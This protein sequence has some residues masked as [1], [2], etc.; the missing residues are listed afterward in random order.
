MSN[1]SKFFEGLAIGGILGF[2]CGLLS[3][4]KPGNEL[5]KELLT[6][7]EDFYKQASES[8]ADMKAKTNQAIAALQAKG[9]DLVKTASENFLAKKESAG[10]HS[11]PHLN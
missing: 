9:E 4:P 6:D 2:F 11:P 8:V 10:E 3:A 7:S 5:R 1:G